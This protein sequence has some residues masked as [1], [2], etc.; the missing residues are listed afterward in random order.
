MSLVAVF[1]ALGL[2]III[3]ISISDEGALDV[4]QENLVEDIRSDIDKVQDENNLLSE[5]RAINL[6]YQVTTFPFL[7][8]GRLQGARIAV[9]SSSNV[10]DEVRNELAGAIQTA[11][12]QVASTTV[13]NSRFDSNEVIKRVKEQLRG[14]PRLALIEEST[15]AAIMGGQLALEVGAPNQPLAMSA[16]Q[17]LLVESA[18]G[19]YSTPVDAVVLVTRSESEDNP[20]YTELEKE[21]LLNMKNLDVV[22]VGGEP[23]DAPRSQVPMLNSVGVPSVDNLESRIGQLSMIYALA[24]ERGA[25]GVK[26]T[27][28]ML[29][30]ILRVPQQEGDEE[31]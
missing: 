22:V 7:V 18:N 19:D 3:G 27:S 16:L 6:R 2:G 4:S 29:I 31:S 14:Y 1:L 17:D 26:P 9:I 25:Y 24:G 20:L 23:S 13:L 15:L 5:E 10:G 21:L 12:G 8:S 30:P 11:G 28:D